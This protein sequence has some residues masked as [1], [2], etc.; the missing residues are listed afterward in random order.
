MLKELHEMPKVPFYWSD[1]CVGGECGGSD[2][3]S[4]LAANP[5]VGSFFDRHVDRGGTCLFEELT[6]AIGLRDYLCSRAVNDQAL[7]RIGTAYDKNEAMCIQIGQFAITPGNFEGGLTTIEEKSMGATIKS[8]TRPIQ[9][10]IK[11]AQ[12]PTH[13]GL[14]LLDT[15]R[16]EYYASRELSAGGDAYTI[17]DMVACGTQI[18]FLTTGRGHDINTPIAPTVKITGN[19]RTFQNMI[20]DIDVDAGQLLTGAKSMEQLTDDLEQLVINICNGEKSKGE[21]LGHQ[22]SELSS[23]FQHPYKVVGPKCK[24]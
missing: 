14:W 16:D 21:A 23:N 11:V 22:E 24:C 10:V 20:D 13:S 15:M 6:E 8:G 12:Q 2:F 1:L 17:L 5:L 4:G 7:E 3:A 18:N 19:S 9:G